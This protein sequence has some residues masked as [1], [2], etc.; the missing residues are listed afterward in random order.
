MA[1]DVDGIDPGSPRKRCGNPLH[2]VLS[3]VEHHDLDIGPHPSDEGLIIR[4]GR[5][6]EGDFGGRLAG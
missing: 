4:H 5:I 2:P 1:D 3:T 6:H